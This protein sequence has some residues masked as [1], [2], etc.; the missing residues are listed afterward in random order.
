MTD[1]PKKP[2]DKPGTLDSPHERQHP[3]TIVRYRK[4]Q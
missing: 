1:K 3:Q 2:E 4:T